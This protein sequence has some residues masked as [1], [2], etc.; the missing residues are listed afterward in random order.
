MNVY[1]TACLFLVV[2]FSMSDASW[3]KTLTDPSLNSPIQKTKKR[4]K[5]RTAHAKVRKQLPP[6]LRVTVTNRSF[7]DAGTVVRPGDRKFTDYAFPPYYSPTAVIDYTS[8][9]ISGPHGGILNP[10]GFYSNW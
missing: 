8:A 10:Y 1:R 5:L 9:N 7:L 4:E 6:R 2:L 3:A